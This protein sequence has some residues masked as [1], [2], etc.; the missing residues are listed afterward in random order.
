MLALL[1]RVSDLENIFI[2]LPSFCVTLQSMHFVSKCWPSLRH[3]R[4]ILFQVFS[5]NVAKT[6]NYLSSKYYFFFH[7][8]SKKRRKIS[9]Y[10]RGGVRQLYQHFWVKKATKKKLIQSR[11]CHDC[12]AGFLEKLLQTLNLVNLVKFTNTRGEHGVNTGWTRGEHGELT[13]CR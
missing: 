6:H 4:C 13:L 8:C 7:V 9:W 1:V 10:S 12:I 3:N 11:G 5:Q 2:S